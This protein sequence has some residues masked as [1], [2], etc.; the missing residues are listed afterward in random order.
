[1]RKKKKREEVFSGDEHSWKEMPE[2]SALVLVK[3][4]LWSQWEGLQRDLFCSVTQPKAQ[5]DCNWNGGAW[6]RLFGALLWFPITI[7]NVQFL[8]CPRINILPFPRPISGDSGKF[9]SINPPGLWKTYWD[10]REGRGLPSSDASLSP[11]EFFWEKGVAFKD[12]K[13]WMHLCLYPGRKQNLLNGSDAC[14]VLDKTRPYFHQVTIWGPWTPRLC[15]RP[16]SSTS[17]LEE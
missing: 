13:P 14:A 4:H 2:G 5:A 15:L 12:F 6:D 7:E 11:V 16:D 10:V 17:V 8:L 9:Y 1:M 3:I